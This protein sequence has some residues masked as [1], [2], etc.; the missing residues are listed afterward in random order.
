MLRNFGGCCRSNF[1]SLLC[2]SALVNPRLRKTD[3]HGDIGSQNLFETVGWMPR[4]ALQPN[5]GVMCNFSVN[6]WLAADQNLA[7]RQFDWLV[8]EVGD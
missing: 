6:Q 5:S 7:L 4:L 2:L 8:A 3:I 1:A